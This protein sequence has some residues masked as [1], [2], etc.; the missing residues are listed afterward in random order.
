[1]RLTTFRLNDYDQFRLHLCS[2]GDIASSLLKGRTSAANPLPFWVWCVSH[3]HHL[4]DD[5]TYDDSLA[6]V[7]ASHAGLPIAH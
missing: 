1:M 5:G 6:L 3:F 4:V 7:C 2:G